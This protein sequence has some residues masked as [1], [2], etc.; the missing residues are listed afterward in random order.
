VLGLGDLA[1]H[2]PERWGDLSFSPQPSAARLDLST[3]A[4]A[5][6]R[7][8]KDEEDASAALMLAERERLVVWRNGVTPTVRALLPEEAMMWDEASKGVRFAILCE[9]AATYA[10]AD[11]AAL[12][13]AQYLQGWIAA[14]MLPK[15]KLARAKRSR[16]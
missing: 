7:A 5:I 13:A 9:L 11:G 14:E 10:D 16:L 4:F 6:W 2:P 12:R 8:L 1:R 3:N 15:A